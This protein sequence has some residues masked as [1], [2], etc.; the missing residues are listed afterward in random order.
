MYSISTANLSKIYSDK[1]AIKDLNLQIPERSIYGFLGENGAGKST[2]LQILSGLVYPS[3]GTYQFFGL[4]GITNRQ[5]IASRIGVLIESPSFIPYL[6][7]KQILTQM[8]RLKGSVST[9]EIDELLAKVKL[10]D[11]EDKKVKTYS[12]GMKQRLGLATALLGE[13]E[14]ILLDEPFSGLD[15]KGV[16]EIKSLLSEFNKKNGVTFFL[17]SHRLREI[18]KLCSDVMVIRN[19][20]TIS[21]GSIEQLIPN[22][23]I[24]SLEVSDPQK[25]SILLQNMSVEHDITDGNW[26][27]VELN[28]T[29]RKELVELLNNNNISIYYLSNEDKFTLEDYYLNQTQEAALS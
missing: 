13:P 10:T 11:A 6:T 18:D 16:I 9:D 28:S 5:L 7:G 12:S 29:N 27:R 2:T 4:D 24:V 8:W 26:I 19:G 3:K 1:F 22:R 21:Q 25:A 23:N 14:L 20:S 15:V 17:S